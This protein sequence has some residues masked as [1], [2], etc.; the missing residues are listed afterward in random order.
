M[1]KRRPTDCVC[2][3]AAFVLPLPGFPLSQPPS[4]SLARPVV[5]DGAGAS[6]SNPRRPPST[7]AKLGPPTS[8][9]ST[10]QVVV[11]TAPPPPPPLAGA[12]CHSALRCGGPPPRKP[13]G[14]RAWS[15]GHGGGEGQIGRPLRHPQVPG[16]ARQ[17]YSGRAAPPLLATDVLVLTSLAPGFAEHLGSRLGG[18][19][20]HCQGRRQGKVRSTLVSCHFICVFCAHKVWNS[21]SCLS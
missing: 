18:P 12:L 21:M 5:R 6:N 3:C 4:P 2:E 15:G 11:E 9:G 16:T 10:S 1:H 8:R 13:V 17:Q 14:A 19:P 7:A 20:Q